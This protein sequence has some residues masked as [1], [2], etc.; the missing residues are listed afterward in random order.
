[1]WTIYIAS[2][3]SAIFIIGLILRFVVW[4]NLKKLFKKKQSKE[5]LEKNP[6]D[7]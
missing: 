6:F 5:I 2:A 1:M 4:D 7:K 3:F